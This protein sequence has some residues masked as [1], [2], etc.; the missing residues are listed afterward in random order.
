MGPSTPI[1]ILRAHTHTPAHSS[2]FRTWRTCTLLLC[3]DT[4]TQRNIPHIFPWT[5]AQ[6]NALL[7]LYVWHD[8]K[9]QAATLSANKLWYQSEF[10]FSSAQPV[11]SGMTLWAAKR[12]KDWKPDYSNTACFV[13]HQN[14]PQ[15]ASE[16]H[17]HLTQPWTNGCIISCHWLP[18]TPVPGSV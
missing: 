14:S 4:Q 2:P 15:S 3:C 6:G 16:Q 12:W 13:L 18:A 9:C 1:N 8:A 10:D 5:D 11:C 17:M 7:I